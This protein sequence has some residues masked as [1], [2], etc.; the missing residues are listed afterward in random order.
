MENGSTDPSFNKEKQF[1]RL[2]HLSHHALAATLLFGGV[3]T[4][5]TSAHAISAREC[6]QK[7]DAAKKAGTL[8][9]QKYKAFKAA[10]CGDASTSAVQKNMTPADKTEATKTPAAPT[11][12]ASPAK[13]AETTASPGAGIASKPT[14]IASGNTVFP[15][16]I[17][18]QYAKL[19]EGK[20]RM[21]TCLDQYNANKTTGGNGSLKW[22]QKGGGYY[23]ECN[24]K[25]K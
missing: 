10:E 11:A 9:G 14:T 3:A 19:S 12:S 20:A 17:A 23:S 24:N 1:V 5:T 21:K 8:N 15:S 7:F 16:A 6:H 13:P 4:A 25:L 18:P 2:K 22:I